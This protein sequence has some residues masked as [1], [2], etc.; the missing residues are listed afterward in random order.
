M[1][2]GLDALLPQLQAAA[3]PWEVVV[4]VVPED[5]S[6]YLN[7]PETLR[8]DSD[9]FSSLLAAL[10]AVLTQ[11]M[12]TLTEI[13][14]YSRPLGEEA[15]DY[16]H[17]LMVTATGSGA[18]DS[19]N[20]ATDSTVETPSLPQN[21]ADF[22]FVRNRMLLSAGDERPNA[23]VAEAL[24]AFHGWPLSE[25]LATLQALADW[26]ADPELPDSRFRTLPET[27]QN[28]ISS[29]QADKGFLRDMK[30]WLS[31]YCHDPEATVALWA[32]PKVEP[33]PNRE[34]GADT[35]PVRRAG[36]RRSPPPGNPSAK[37]VTIDISGLSAFR[38]QELPLILG[39]CILIGG[40][41]LLM[42]NL[43]A[44]VGGWAVLITLASIGS[45][46][47]AVFQ[48]PILGGICLI[49]LVFCY[50][51]SGAVIFVVP[52]ASVGGLLGG[53]LAIALKMAAPRG[54]GIFSAQSLRL[55]TA[56]AC[57][58]LII[59]G[60]A[61]ARYGL[62][63]DKVPQLARPARQDVL[64]DHQAS[65]TFTV[66]RKT[67][68][69]QGGVAVFIPKGRFVNIYA[70]SAPLQQKLLDSF[71]LERTEPDLGT[72]QALTDD[73]G[74][75][76]QVVVS[77]R[78]EDNTPQLRPGYQ[79]NAS[80]S[81]KGREANAQRNVPGASPDLQIERLEPFE[82]GKAQLSLKFE[83]GEPSGFAVDLKLDSF[84]Y[85]RDTRD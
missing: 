42:G 64:A 27:G 28:L 68:S 40:L 72:L 57:V 15:V 70:F 43:Y 37:E 73:E 51:V 55:L 47:A 85:V 41:S 66:N 9:E 80:W 62:T 11:G 58:I 17:L 2:N 45:G 35:T 1:V 21:L 20:S 14:V 24:Q 74:Y 49:V 6:L 82:N 79:V 12:P 56:V 71:V 26:L 54:Q 30:V 8:P 67:F 39:T 44:L 77:L 75:Q 5:P 84:V 52:L 60:G 76:A 16:Q 31:R 19:A 69:F 7:R 38:T 83:E 34:I 36:T 48:Q 4:Q 18:T 59:H 63:G 81:G 78:L 25:Q 23:K 10:Q 65:G 50:P 46:L 61:I 22:C 3:D 32:P 13:A 33:P 53:I 29:L